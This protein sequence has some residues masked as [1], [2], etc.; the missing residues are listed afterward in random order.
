MPG[1]RRS[2]VVRPLVCVVDRSADGAERVVPLRA[3]LGAD[4]LGAVGRLDS[5]EGTGDVVH[6]VLLSCTSR[7]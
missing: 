2:L 6:D 7:C 3:V 1:P 5:D 4:A